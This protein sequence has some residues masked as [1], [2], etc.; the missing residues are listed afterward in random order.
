[1]L[2]TSRRNHRFLESC[3]DPLLYMVQERPNNLYLVKKDLVGVCKMI[4]WMIVVM[5]PSVCEF[6]LL[7]NGHFRFTVPNI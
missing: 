3:V 7:I 4:I 1:M 2:P 6:A 5:L